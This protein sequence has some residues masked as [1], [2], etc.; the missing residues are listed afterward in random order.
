[1][2]DSVMSVI[3]SQQHRQIVN[4]NDCQPLNVK[5][6]FTEAFGNDARHFKHRSLKKPC[7]YSLSVEVRNFAEVL[8]EP[9]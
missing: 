5:V 8:V 4:V 7:L 2:S 9:L 1:M 6:T 3:V